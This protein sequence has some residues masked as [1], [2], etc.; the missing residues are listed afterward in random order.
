MKKV[1]SSECRAGRYYL[2]YKKIARSK[3][4]HGKLISLVKYSRN[5]KHL[6]VATIS[7]FGQRYIDYERHGGG[8]HRWYKPFNSP[9]LSERQRLARKTKEIQLVDDE[10]HDLYWEGELCYRVKEIYE[11]DEH[12]VL[13]HGNVL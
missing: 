5:R 13:I 7:T 12:E 1:K 3:A 6:S 9:W 10:D 8:V 11:L 2:I 4:G